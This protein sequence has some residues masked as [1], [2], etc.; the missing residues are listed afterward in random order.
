MKQK[1]LLIEDDLDIRE[2]TV[3]MLELL[4]YRV[5]A[6]SNGEQGLEQAIELIPDLILCDIRMP[7]MN[8]YH[9]LEHIRKL[10]GLNNS[11]FVFFSS[12]CE[13]KEIETGMLMGADDY[14]IKPFTEDDLLDKLKKHL[15]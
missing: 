10:P 11:R 15:G 5:L 6:A 7:V 1:I 3:E 13:K 2:N 4:D 14:I 9:F 12:S 8:G